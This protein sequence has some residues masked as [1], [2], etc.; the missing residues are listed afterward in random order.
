MIAYPPFGAGVP[1]EVV[2]AIVA[3]YADGEPVMSLAARFGMAPGQIE[4]LVAH[5]VAAPDFTSQGP[6]AP[7]PAPAPG[8]PGPVPAYSPAPGWS[9]PAVPSPELIDA[10]VAGYADG[11][12]VVS[13]AARFGMAPGQI[14]ALV[15]H[16]VAGPVAPQ[17]GFAVPPAD[18]PQGPSA[19]WPLPA[20]PVGFPQGYPAPAQPQFPPAGFQPPVS[21]VSFTTPRTSGLLIA[22]LVL[23][24]ISFLLVVAFALF[25]IKAQGG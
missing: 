1:Q 5:D 3:G 25:W 6:A 4:A 18:V 19:A 11:E 16:D 17:P 15:A 12:P 9:V 7:T 2:D 20:G 10:I 14:E 23:G 22:V 24:G 21:P 8:W 13:L